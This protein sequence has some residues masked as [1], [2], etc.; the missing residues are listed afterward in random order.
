M[1]PTDALN[2]DGSTAKTFE[3]YAAS[4]YIDSE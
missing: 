3:R 2:R 1:T 4:R